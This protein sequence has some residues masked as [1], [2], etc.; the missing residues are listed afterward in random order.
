[1]PLSTRALPPLCSELGCLPYGCRP[2][3]QVQWRSHRPTE[4]TCT[5]ALPGSCPPPGENHLPPA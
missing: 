5:A 2:C 3:M 1:M 4:L